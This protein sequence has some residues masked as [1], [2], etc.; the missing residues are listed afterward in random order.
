MKGEGIPDECL[1]FFKTGLGFEKCQEKLN[2]PH[3][4]EFETASKKCIGVSNTDV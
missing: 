4:A 2:E 3:A 1:G